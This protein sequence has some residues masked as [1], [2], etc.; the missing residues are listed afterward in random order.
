MLSD[1]QITL[2]WLFSKKKLQQTVANRVNEIHRLL[3]NFTWHY[4]PNRMQSSKIPYKKDFISVS[5]NV[6]SMVP[7]PRLVD[8]RILV[9]NL[10]CQ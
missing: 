10:E 3:P 7:W 5:Q 1:S 8:R 2:R 9:A 6:L 4:C